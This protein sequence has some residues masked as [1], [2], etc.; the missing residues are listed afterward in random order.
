ML[1]WPHVL[2]MITALCVW[3]GLCTPSFWLSC[4]CP[5][6]SEPARWLSGWSLC[7][8]PEVFK[9]SPWL[10][11]LLWSCMVKLRS[12]QS[13][14]DFFLNNITVQYSGMSWGGIGN[15]FVMPQMWLWTFPYLQQCK[16]ACMWW[17]GGLNFRVVDEECSPVPSHQHHSDE[18]IR[19]LKMRTMNAKYIVQISTI[20]IMLKMGNE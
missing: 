5:Y 13:H 3:G 8:S 17:G 12:L 7:Q 9:L 16:I 15:I 4:S 1:A 6:V 11:A 14:K 10:S 18:P 20:I 19:A 2:G